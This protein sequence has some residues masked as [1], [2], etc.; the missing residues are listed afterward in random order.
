MAIRRACTATESRPRDFTYV[1]DAVEA[2]LL[3][4]V[5]T[6]ADGQVYNVGTGR[7]TSV[8]ALAR[9]IIAVTGAVVEPAHVDRRDIDNIRRRVLNIE[10]IRRELR[11]TPSVTIEEGLKQT[12]SWL[13]EGGQ[14]AG[15]AEAAAQDASA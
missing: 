10:K 4:L 12:Y 14:H 15:P 11:W 3:T 9:E 5:S 7:E 13:V 6:K 2:T 1:D 8:N